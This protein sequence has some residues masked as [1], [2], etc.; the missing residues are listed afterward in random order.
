MKHRKT[1]VL[2][3]PS[4][5]QSEWRESPDFCMGHLNHLIMGVGSEKTHWGAETFIPLRNKKASF[6]CL[7]YQWRSWT[8]TTHPAIMSDPTFFSEM[9]Q[10][11]PGEESQIYYHLAITR[12]HLLTGSMEA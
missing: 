8:P 2:P 12:P 7:W 6:L 5:E 3:L 1:A 4:S 11:R 9:Y 10:K